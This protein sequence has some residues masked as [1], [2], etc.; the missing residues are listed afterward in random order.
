MKII[1]TI[2]LSLSVLFFAAC[3]DSTNEKASEK[4][5]SRKGKLNNVSEK[6][7]ETLEDLMPDKDAFK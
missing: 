6:P 7:V 1:K 5:T 4:E 3:N 2:L